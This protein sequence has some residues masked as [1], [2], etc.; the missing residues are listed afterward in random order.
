M[1]EI[2]HG[3]STPHDEADEITH[4][5]FIPL[6]RTSV[7][8]N[9]HAFEGNLIITT[10]MDLEEYCTSKIK[11]L[12]SNLNTSNINR[13]NLVQWSIECKTCFKHRAIHAFSALEKH[14]KESLLEH[15]KVFSYQ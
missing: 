3:A 8:N 2:L 1:V 5:G 12:G 9:E 6:P 14:Q 11:N 13:K 10:D 4:K 7:R 15:V